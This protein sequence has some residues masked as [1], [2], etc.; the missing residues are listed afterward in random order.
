VKGLYPFDPADFAE[1]RIRQPVAKTWG[2]V[3][4]IAEALSVIPQDRARSK[5]ASLGGAGGLSPIT[6]PES[7]AGN[8]TNTTTRRTAIHAQI[9]RRKAGRQPDE[10]P[11]ASVNP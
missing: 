9:L 1:A 8:T 11:L 6:M 3:P 7:I 4:R 5:Q 10:D 2:I